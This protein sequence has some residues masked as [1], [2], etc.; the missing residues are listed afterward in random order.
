MFRGMLEQEWIEIKGAREHN[1]RGVDVRIPRNRLTVVTGLSGSGKSSLAFD[2]LFAEGQ[3]RYVESLS[4]Y[5]R[6]FLDQLQKPN[7]EHILGLSPAIAIE[8][9]MGS[10][11]PRSTVATITELHDYLRLLYASIG[12]P[13]CPRCGKPVVRHSAEEMVDAIESL[14]EKSRV[15][16]LAPGGW[17]RVGDGAGLIESVQR[18]GFVRVRVDGV[19]L[20]VE[21]VVAASLKR[22]QVVEAVVDRLVLGGGG[23]S[24]LTDSVELALREGDAAV[25]VLWQQAGESEWQEQL[26]SEENMCVDCGVRFPKLEPRNFS[27]NS[28]H[29][30]C[31][32]CSGLG[33]ELVFDAELV[34]P[35]SSLSLAKGAVPAWRK[36]G[37]ALVSHY[38]RLIKAFCEH[39]GVDAAAPLSSWPDE[40]RK[41]LMAG[42]GEELIEGSFRKGRGY[43]RDQRVFEGVMPNLARRYET[44]DSE[45]V[46][47]QLRQYMVRKRCTRCGGGRLKPKSRAVLVGGISIV[48]LLAMPVSGAHEFLSGLTLLAMEEKI[49]GELIRELVGRLQLLVDVGLEYLTLDREGSTLSGGEAQRVRLATQIGSGL[50]GVL[51]VLDEPTIGLHPRDNDRLLEL[52]KALRDRGNTVVVVEHDEQ[53]IREADW[54]VDMG[55]GAGTHGGEVVY[56]GPP[57]GLEQSSGL[58]AL[59]LNGSEVV[60]LPAMRR[61]PDGR[62]LVLTGVSE[63]NLRDVDVSFPLGA[64]VCVTGVSGSGKSSLVDDVLR[65]ALVRELSG[66]RERPGAH[67]SLTGVE[68]VDK[69][70]VVDQSPI[71]RTPRSNPATYTGLFSVVRQLFALTPTAKVR[72]FGPGRFSF[73][74][75]GGRCETCKGDGMLKLEMHFLP[76]VYVTCERCSGKR[77]NAET[78]EVH[79]GG[80]T[81][82][83]VLD[84][85]VSEAMAFFHSVPKV[86]RRL[87][88]LEEVGLGYLKLGQSATTLSG[89]EAQR[90]KLATELSRPAAGGTVYILDEPTTGLHFA[91]V[92]RLL[93]VLVRLRDAG[94]SVIVVEHNLDVVKCADWVIDLGPG[95][96][97]DGGCIV[98]AGPPEEVAA[99][100]A[101]VTGQYLGRLLV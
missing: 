32:T 46:R 52:L 3:R 31:G 6:Q 71:G 49:A 20:P 56:C 41:R 72:G 81:I 9:R 60:P 45:L 16:L 78:L 91:D 100:A 4:A 19:V 36:G 89:G 42:S 15:M 57:T 25:T 26:Y 34:A 51:Y 75:K 61:P 83:D 65:R 64:M 88:V 5:A 47:H 70:V 37:R 53:V 23:R 68:L 38:R 80:K 90:L 82:S 74:V 30:A 62:E 8:Q 86:A 77:Y 79:Y 99:C 98:V 94:H 67:R 10:S 73:N 43:C 55:P 29:G 48:E 18:K 44:T 87:S 92:R 24:R 50:T 59:Y 22:G 7:V 2:T 35:D 17:E 96:G 13:H 101:S 21:E 69:V 33:T 11:N 63:H 54:V 95:G 97:Q 76:D 40:V 93:E 27:F 14:P 28:P 12:K 58:T 66:G 1:L 85:T 84:M 39:Y